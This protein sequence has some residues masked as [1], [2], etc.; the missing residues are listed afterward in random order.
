MLYLPTDSGSKEALQKNEASPQPRVLK[1]GSLLDSI[2]KSV[3]LRTL[4]L[5]CAC[6]AYSH[7]TTI[8]FMQAVKQTSP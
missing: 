2:T 4:D 5:L 3:G 6:I 1:H 8:R 7:T